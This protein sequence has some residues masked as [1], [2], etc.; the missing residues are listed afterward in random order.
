MRTALI[1]LFKDQASVTLASLAT[2][3]ERMKVPALILC[4]RLTCARIVASLA[5]LLVTAANLAS[6]TITSSKHASSCLVKSA[7]VRFATQAT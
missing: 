7:S 3:S 6:I 4:A 5:S 2:S 1:A